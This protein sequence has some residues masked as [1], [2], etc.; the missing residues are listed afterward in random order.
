[1][2]NSTMDDRSCE[3]VSV[4]ATAPQDA[5]QARPRYPGRGRAQCFRPWFAIVCIPQD[6][7]HAVTDI[8]QQRQQ[9]MGRASGGVRSTLRYNCRRVPVTCT[10]TDM[11]QQCELAESQGGTRA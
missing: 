8:K 7:Q 1:M 11:Q 4:T 6:L 3:R 5:H 10:R 2:H 9:T